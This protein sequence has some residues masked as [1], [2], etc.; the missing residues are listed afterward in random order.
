MLRFLTNSAGLLFWLGQAGAL[1]LLISLVARSIR[2]HSSFVQ[3]IPTTDQSKFSKAFDVKGIAVTNFSV[4]ENGNR[5]KLEMAFDARNCGDNGNFVCRNSAR[6]H[7]FSAHREVVWWW[8]QDDLQR[9]LFHPCVQPESHV[10]SRCLTEISNGY[11]GF[12]TSHIIVV[13][14]FPRAYMYVS[15]QFH[16]S[17]FSILP[18]RR[19]S[20]VDGFSA[21]HKRIYGQSGLFPSCIQQAKGDDGVYKSDTENAPVR[22][23]GAVIPFLCGLFLFYGGAWLNYLNWSW[24]DN[25]RKRRWGQIGLVA[26]AAIM[27]TGLV[28]MFF[29]AST[30]TA[31][32]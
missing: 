3:T 9:K 32:G 26:S 6:R 28:L 1:V 18:I 25:D 13:K 4:G 16:L 15:S 8:R 27:G 20:S 5:S 21:L 11:S 30:Y 29:V 2:G 10:V 14:D 23:R 17:Q 19:A 31:G 22:N 7:Y 24:L 12:T